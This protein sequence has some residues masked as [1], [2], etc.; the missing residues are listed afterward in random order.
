MTSWDIHALRLKK[1]ACDQATVEGLDGIGVGETLQAFGGPLARQL[2]AVHFCKCNF[3]L[4]PLFGHVLH[5]SMSLAFGCV[6]TSAEICRC[7]K[8]H[9]DNIFMF[10]RFFEN[11][12][13]PS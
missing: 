10:G 4:I 5:M 1:Y 13:Q 12:G 3:G 7:I 2:I 9:K 11:G 6:D 8:N